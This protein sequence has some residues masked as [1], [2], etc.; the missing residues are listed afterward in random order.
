MGEAHVHQLAVLDA[1]I[2]VTKQMGS[3]HRVHT[4]TSEINVICYVILDV[5]WAHVTK[6]R[7]AFRALRATGTSGVYRDV[8]R[9]V[10][11]GNVIRLMGPVL[12]AS[13]AIGVKDVLKNAMHIVPDNVIT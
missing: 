7:R 6:N 9:V 5:Q 1:K 4:I 2:H 8:E 13:L 3:V 10:R 11:Q 12:R